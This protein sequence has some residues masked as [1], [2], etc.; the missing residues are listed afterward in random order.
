MFDFYAR[1]AEAQALVETPVEVREGEPVDRSAELARQIRQ[2]RD[3]L[4]KE[5]E[6][7]EAQVERDGERIVVRM[8]VQGSFYQASAVLSP[9]AT[10]LLTK[11]GH[12]IAQTGV[13]IP[14]EGQPDPGPINCHAL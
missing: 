9:E 10:P 12:A 5:I 11:V 7:G 3:V 2:L 6:Q 14:I 1:I 8:A 13:R 4:S